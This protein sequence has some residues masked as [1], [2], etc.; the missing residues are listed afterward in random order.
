MSHA[1]GAS[2]RKERLARDRAGDDEEM[3]QGDAL[4]F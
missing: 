1:I 2:E 3:V 4:F